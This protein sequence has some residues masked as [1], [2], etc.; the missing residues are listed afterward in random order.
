M[1]YIHNSAGKFPDGL[2]CA[3][4]ISGTVTFLCSSQYPLQISTKIFVYFDFWSHLLTQNIMTHVH[5]SVYHQ[6]CT[7]SSLFLVLICYLLANYSGGVWC[8]SQVSTFL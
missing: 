6:P 3:G 2:I 8:S 4:Y 5:V 1:L 7:S